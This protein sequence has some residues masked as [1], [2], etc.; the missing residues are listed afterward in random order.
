MTD[1]ENLLKYGKHLRFCELVRQPFTGR[2]DSH[3][4]CTCGF[5]EALGCELCDKKGYVVNLKMPKGGF[6]TGNCPD[7][8]NI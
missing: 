1:K 3:W 4:S 2:T 7:C 6:L 8:G 5:S